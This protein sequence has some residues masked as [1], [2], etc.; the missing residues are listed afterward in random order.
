LRVTT[1][2]G[3]LLFG[4]LRLGLLARARRDTCGSG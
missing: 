2:S 3:F 1:T 4:M